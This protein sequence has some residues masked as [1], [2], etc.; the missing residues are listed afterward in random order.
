VKSKVELFKLGELRLYG[1]R[2]MVHMQRGSSV[3]VS[4]LPTLMT[5]GI[6][7]VGIS[8]CRLFKCMNL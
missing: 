2:L 5:L 3:I 7:D 6:L 4:L 8:K 1:M